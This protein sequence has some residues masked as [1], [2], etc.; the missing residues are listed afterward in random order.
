MMKNT[1][2]CFQEGYEA[3]FIFMQILSPTWPREKALTN[4]DN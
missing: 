3:H 2:E 4:D 1:I